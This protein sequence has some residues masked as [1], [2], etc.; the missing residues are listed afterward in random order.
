MILENPELRERIEAVLIK[1]LK[2]F[3]RVEETDYLSDFNEN[4]QLLLGWKNLKDN[5]GRYM[6]RKPKT[7]NGTNFNT[8]PEK[9]HNIF[10]CKS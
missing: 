4:Y 8:S 1:Y 9:H 6:Q 2:E 5:R 3:W 7:R 10:F